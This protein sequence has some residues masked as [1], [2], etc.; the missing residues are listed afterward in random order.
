M[1]NKK[2]I[3]ICIPS[4]KHI[5]DIYEIIN[6]YADK[7]LL[8]HRSLQDITNNLNQFYIAIIDKIVVGCISK[9]FYSD[10]L[11]EIRSLAIKNKYKKLGIGKMLVEKVIKE[12]KEKRVFALTYTPVFFQK[13]GFTTIQKEILPEKIW[14]DCITCPYR[15][16]C[17]EIAVGI[18]FI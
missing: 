9:K 10:D 11:V 12:E 3:K 17:K 7:G 14:A 16:D 1:C 6:F 13:V 18:C 8:L 15:F 2:D 5:K 4:I